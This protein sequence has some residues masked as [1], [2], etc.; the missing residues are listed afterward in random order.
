MLAKFTRTIV[1]QTNLH[2]TKTAIFAILCSFFVPEALPVFAQSGG[3]TIDEKPSTQLAQAKKRK[4]KKKKRKKKSDDAG[5]GVAPIE[6]D[7]PEPAESGAPAS[8]HGAQESPG[9]YKWHVSLLSDFKIVNQQ[10]GDAKSGSGNYDLDALGLYVIGESLEIGGG[11]VFKEKT[12]KYKTSSNKTTSYLLKLKGIYN[13]GNIHSD[14]SVFFTGLSLGFGSNSVKIEGDEV[15][16]S[17]SKSSITQFGLGLGMHWFVDSNV[18]FTAEFSYDTGTLK[19][20]G[21]GDPTKFSEIH[22]AKMGF[23]LFL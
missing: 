9:L 7:S 8:V 16:S 21:G 15:D 19:G 13:F 10:T 6:G 4:K 17:E 18:A 20:D 12:E 5:Q 2:N 1:T 14:S 3:S 22:I 11:M 23:S